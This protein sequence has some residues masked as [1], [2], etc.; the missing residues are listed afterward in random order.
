M[1]ASVLGVAFF[2]AL[3]RSFFL[4]GTFP[5]ST[6]KST[7][8]GKKRAF[9]FDFVLFG[10]LH[11]CKRLFFCCFF[12]SVLSFRVLGGTLYCVGVFF[13]LLRLVLRF[14]L[15]RL[16]FSASLGLNSGRYDWEYLKFFP[17]S[18]IFKKSTDKEKRVR[19][20]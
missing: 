4:G 2:C 19:E 17:S 18:L 13:A 16:L 9:L 20:I 5:C 12:R 1:A 6:Q 11:I 7:T 14:F 8:D 3:L 10:L 15:V